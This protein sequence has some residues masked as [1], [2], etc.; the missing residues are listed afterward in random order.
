VFWSTANHVFVCRGDVTAPYITTS[1]QYWHIDITHINKCH[2]ADCLLCWQFVCK[3]EIGLLVLS[4]LT[5][6]AI[7]S[8]SAPL[9]N[10][11]EIYLAVSYKDWSLSIKIK[12]CFHRQ[13]NAYRTM[14]KSNIFMYC[15]ICDTS[16]RR[17]TLS[18]YWIRCESSV[19]C[20][21]LFAE[22]FKDVTVRH[23]QILRYSLTPPD[24]TVV[25]NWLLFP[26]FLWWSVLCSSSGL[27]SRGD[28][29]LHMYI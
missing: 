14:R 23:H 6:V 20:N 26:H 29:Q 17:K 25:C 2:T 21:V 15:N 12:Q 24:S 5:A 1:K 19:F 27:S 16:D 3:T 11:S 13:D 7:S 9:H 4:A 8:E 18:E 10:G 22:H 28:Q